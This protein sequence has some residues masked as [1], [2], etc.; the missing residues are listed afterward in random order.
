MM[1]NRMQRNSLGPG[2]R[3]RMNRHY[4]SITESTKN[5]VENMLQM[6]ERT[7][8]ITFVHVIS[9]QIIQNHRY[10]SMYHRFDF[11]HLTI[12]PQTTNSRH[13]IEFFI[14]AFIHLCLVFLLSH[15]FCSCY[16]TPNYFASNYWWSIA[17]HSYFS[18]N[19]PN[20]IHSADIII[21]ITTNT[22]HIVF[23]SQRLQKKIFKSYCFVVVPFISSVNFIMYKFE[24]YVCGDVFELGCIAYI[25]NIDI[26]LWRICEFLLK[27]FVMS[28]VGT[29]FRYF[30]QRSS[31]LHW[32]EW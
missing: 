14:R 27:L 16:S 4:I 30:E 13:I 31:L 3:T 12:P 7:P 22:K 28:Y 20:I 24:M 17:F 23:I 10:D 8:D 9:L 25:P 1:K 15:L 18:L 29:I 32:I 5:I 19:I 26:L 6:Y 2:A 11:V 21:I